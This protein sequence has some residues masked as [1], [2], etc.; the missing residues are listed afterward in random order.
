MFRKRHNF[1]MTA[2][3]IRITTSKLQEPIT[4]RANALMCRRFYDVS[5]VVVNLGYAW[6][7]SVHFSL[8]INTIIDL[9]MKKVLW[10]MLML[11]SSLSIVAQEAE[12]AKPLTD[13][14]VVR[15]VSA[16]DLEGKEYEAVVMTFKSTSPDYF[17]NKY[18]VKVT[19]KDKEGK[20]IWK[21]TLKNV[22]LYV[23]SDGQIQVGKN[24][25]YMILVRKSQIMDGNI[26]IVRIKEGV[27]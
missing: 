5:K 17:T 16:L 22:F 1:F 6:T 13:M 11:V 12:K 2:P 4:H 20:T 8:I 21:K 3:H 19:V 24:N 14:E 23:F 15:K 26:G 7:M 18:R 10:F 9:H 27:N 25:F